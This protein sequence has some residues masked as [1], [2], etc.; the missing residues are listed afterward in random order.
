MKQKKTDPNNL[1]HVAEIDRRLLGY[2]DPIT[3]LIQFQPVLELFS[4]ILAYFSFKN[5]SSNNFY[6]IPRQK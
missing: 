3:Y 6:F 1:I 5:N 2:R 4:G